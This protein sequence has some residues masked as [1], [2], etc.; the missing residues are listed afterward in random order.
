MNLNGSQAYFEI[1]TQTEL[2]KRCTY[3]CVEKDSTLDFSV[4]FFTHRVLSLP[5]N[6]VFMKINF[7]YSL[8]A[9]TIGFMIQSSLALA[10]QPWQITKTRESFDLLAKQALK[11][12]SVDSEAV[13]AAVTASS[14][15]IFDRYQLR[16]DSGTKVLSKL[17]VGGTQTNPVLKATIR[18]CVSFICQTVKLDAE[19]SVQPV[20]SPTCSSSYVMLIDLERSSVELSDIYDQIKVDICSK[21]TT[22]GSDLTLIANAR[23]AANYSDGFIKNEIMKFLQLQIPSIIT[24]INQTLTESSKQK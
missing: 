16:I 15:D 19:V 4:L 7:M 24:A 10:T 20:Q 22:T 17:Q 11:I 8:G 2:A 21:K 12:N 6:E 23:H 3:I 9:L 18:K 14:K 13:L 1:H 5:R